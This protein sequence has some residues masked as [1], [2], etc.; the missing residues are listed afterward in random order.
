MGI[1]HAL[2]IEAHPSLLHI[3]QLE[4]CFHVPQSRSSWRP[5]R[6]N[7]HTGTL[8]RSKPR[9][10][11][12]G[13]LRPAGRHSHK[14]DRCTTSWP[15]QTPLVPGQLR[16][17]SATKASIQLEGDTKVG[18]FQRCSTR[19]KVGRGAAAAQSGYAICSRGAERDARRQG[20]AA[21]VTPPHVPTA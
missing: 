19:Q 10:N 21:D 20:S 17:V 18:R 3:L 2:S 14:S 5:C 1:D 6:C 9:Q 15:T 13:S 7:P 11:T 4:S 16:A 12:R 8:Y